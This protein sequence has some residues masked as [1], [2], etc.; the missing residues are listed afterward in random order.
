MF[1]EIRAEK[2][3]FNTKLD[4]KTKV[5]SDKSKL[6]KMNKWLFLAMVIVPLTVFISIYISLFSSLLLTIMIS[7]VKTRLFL[8][9]NQNIKTL[10]EII[11]EF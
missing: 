5:F 8:L 4:I 11:A 6:E 1:K 7:Y 9:E 3:H 10:K 2:R